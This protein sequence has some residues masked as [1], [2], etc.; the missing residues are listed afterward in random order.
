VNPAV[1]FPKPHEVQIE[2]RPHPEPGAG[3]VVIRAS[4][5]LISPG[6]ELTILRGA[7]EADSAWGA[8]GRF[9]FTPGYSSIGVVEAVGDGVEAELV[10]RT[11]ASYAPHAL[12]SSVPAAVL[13]PVPPEVP[14]EQATLFTLA[15]TTMNGVRRSRLTWGET[16]TVYGAGLLG[17]LTARLALLAG[18]RWV[19]VV[20]VSAF[21]L[22]LLPQSDRVVAV[23]AAHS[24]PAAAV[25]EFVEAVDVVFELTGEPELIPREL[26]VLRRQGRFVVLS[27]PRGSG[28]LFNFHDLCNSPSIEIIGAHADSSPPVATP[29]NPWT[30]PRHAELFF[31]LVAAG[32]L[33]VEPLITSVVGYE[34]APA[35]YRRLLGSTDELGVVLD[36]SKA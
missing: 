22:G 25:R 18:A 15:E 20:D 36:W 12:Y 27:S 31:D 16:V 4:S 35:A 10:G 14:R 9:P 34:E 29:D 7:Y 23:D 6:T 11:V 28:T 8:Y 1:V 26:D 30:R 19:F 17:Q 5:T 2:E 33:D 3:E 24:D 13:R 21:R 32:E